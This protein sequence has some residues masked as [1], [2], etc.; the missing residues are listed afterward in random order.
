MSSSIQEKYQAYQKILLQTADLEATQ[1]VL[2]W[3]KE[4]YMPPAGNTARARQLALLAGMSHEIAAGNELG[5]LLLALEAEQEQLSTKAAQN[6]ALSL[7]DFRR[8]QKYTKAFVEKR[9]MIGSVTYDAWV[10]ARESNNA[11]DYLP[12]LDQMIQLKREEAELLGYEQHP[13]DALIDLFEPEMTVAEL[14]V[15]FKEVK[16]QLVDFVAQLRS[17]PQIDN[18]FLQQHYPKDQQWEFGLEM[19]R[20]IGYDFNA[21]RQD[22]SRHP[23]TTTFGPGDIRVTTRIDEH[24][25]DNMTWSCI[26]EGG[27]ALYEQ[28]LPAEDFGLPSG[29]YCSLGIHESQS[30]LWENNVGRSLAFWQKWYP[31]LKQRFNPQLATVSLSDFYKGINKIQPSLVRTESDELHYHFHILIRYEIE[32]QLIEGQLATKDLPEYWASKYKE[33]LNLD[34]PDDRQ[35][36]LQDIHWSLGSFGYFPTYSLGSFYA[37]QF[38]QQAE[39]DIENLEQLLASGDC[40]PLL[41]WLRTH[42]HQHG[43]TYS[44][45]KLCQDITGEKLNFQY[46]MKYVQKKY[47]EIYS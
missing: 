13:Y 36:I 19:L 35:G 27:H 23:F 20:V 42:V 2:A 44:A 43:Q 9:S 8:Q 41:K 34:I 14:D 5:D 11:Q 25:F 10:K 40:Q 21:G 1:A 39:K 4:V 7:K 46:F 6:V 45:N 17:K 29:K 30:R 3:D 15:L 24:N 12:A 38:Y 47:G 28:G 33:Y 37:A 31:G 32:K 18:A 26:H 22:I 16:E